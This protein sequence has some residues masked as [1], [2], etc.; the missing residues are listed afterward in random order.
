MISSSSLVEEWNFHNILSIDFSCE[1]FTNGQLLSQM[2]QK[3][4]E[5]VFLQ[6]SMFSE[7]P[8]LSLIMHPSPFHALAQN[9]TE[10]SFGFIHNLFSKDVQKS[11]IVLF[12]SFEV[13]LPDFFVESFINCI[14]KHQELVTAS[15]FAA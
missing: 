6:I 11:K 14:E 1:T 12:G 13:I 8:S 10:L 9:S 15:N 3:L 5:H 2:V 4:F 7:L